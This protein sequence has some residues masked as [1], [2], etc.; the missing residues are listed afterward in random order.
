MV[1]SRFTNGETEAPRVDGNFPALVQRESELRCDLLRSFC[2]LQ[3]QALWCGES[4]PELACQ[5]L[6]SPTAPWVPPPRLSSPVVLSPPLPLRPMGEQIPGG[7]SW[8][9]LWGLGRAQESAIKGPSG[10]SV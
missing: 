2:S 3:P 8:D 5:D 4:L 1:D 7:L 6:G 9:C 10:G